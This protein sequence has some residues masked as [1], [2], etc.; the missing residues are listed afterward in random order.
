MALWLMR[1][2]L[3]CGE[4]IIDVSDVRPARGGNRTASTPAGGHR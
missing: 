1:A 4:A 2:G 3:N